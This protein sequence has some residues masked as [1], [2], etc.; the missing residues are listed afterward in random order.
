MVLSFLDGSQT[1]KAT[2]DG[3]FFV[4]ESMRTPFFR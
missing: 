2:R 1:K 3:R 4:I